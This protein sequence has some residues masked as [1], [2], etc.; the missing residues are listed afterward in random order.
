MFEKKEN[1]Y[2]ID[3]VSDLQSNHP[4]VLHRYKLEVANIHSFY[5]IFSK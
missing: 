4:F 3:I 5:M 1:R 2:V